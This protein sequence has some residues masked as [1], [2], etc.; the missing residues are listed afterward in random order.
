MGRKY[1]YDYIIIGSGPAGSAAAFTL[2]KARKRVAIVEKNHL[3]GSN[4]NTRDIPYG[5]ALDF[6]N[7]YHKVSRSP[8][9]GRQEIS[10]NFPTV[11]ARQLKATIES[12]GNNQKSLTM[13]AS[14]VSMALPIS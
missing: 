12:G 14:C 4:L 6:A 8:E 11:V 9:F 2:A 13:L 5:V 3:G 10:F 7:T 1:D